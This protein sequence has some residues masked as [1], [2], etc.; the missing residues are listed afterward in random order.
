MRNTN[1]IRN[2]ALL[3]LVVLAAGCP[4]LLDDY[5]LGF[6]DAF[7]G[8]D[9][10]AYYWQGYDDSYDTVEDVY[11]Y[12]AG[13]DIPEVAE[14]AYDAGYYD[15]LWYA[16]NDG[17][18]VAYD[19][20]FTIGFSEGYDA[21]FYSDYLDFLAGDFHI[22]YDNGGW[23]DGYNDGFSEGRVF[24]AWDYREGWDLD[25]LDALLDYQSE[26]DVCVE[27]ADH[28]LLCTGLDGPVVLYEY[29]YDPTALKSGRGSRTAPNRLSIRNAGVAK[30]GDPPPLTY[31]ALSPAR[32]DALNKRPSTTSRSARPLTLGTTWLER[33]NAYLGATKA[34]AK[35]APRSRAVAE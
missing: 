6:D 15:G 34:A 2:A 27:L 3:G 26:T 31:R 16:Y 12:Y 18:F 11:V 21:A 7:Y 13:G 32:Q 14:P 20:A 1:V 22:E 10:D 17:Y 30:A 35:A 23:D 4:E 8:A 28:T 9:G 19:Y 33:V 25:W 24:G 5:D 29:G